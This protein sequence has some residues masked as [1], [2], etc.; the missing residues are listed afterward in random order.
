LDRHAD[1]TLAVL[2]YKTQPM[3]V[4]RNKPDEIFEDCQL[5]FYGLLD[6]EVGQGAWV[7][8]EDADRDGQA[9]ERAVMLPDYDVIVDWLTRQV[10]EDIVRLRAG[11]SMPAFGDESACRYCEAR[12]LCR[13][14]YWEGAV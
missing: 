2:D 9:A 8:L 14:G 5:A 7:A 10:G 3:R 6:P 4:L 13:K 1:G 11:D 12:G